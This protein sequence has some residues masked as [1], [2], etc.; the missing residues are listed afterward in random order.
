MVFIGAVSLTGIVVNDGIVLV[1]AINQ[2]R[3]GGRALPDAVAAAAEARLRPVI[4]TTI[5]TIAGLLPLTLNLA[6]G[7]EFWVPLG[8]ALISG[9][10][11]STGLTLFVVPVLYSLFEGVPQ[12]GGAA[13]EEAVRESAA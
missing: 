12:A 8:I 3:R 7:G 13:L 11:V 6:G 1:D 5:T 2:E 10:V 4:L 9:L